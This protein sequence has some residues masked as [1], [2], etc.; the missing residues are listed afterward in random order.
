MNINVPS[1]INF[2]KNIERNN[3]RFEKLSNAKKRIAIAKDAMAQILTGSY[4][5]AP[6]YYV[7]STV[8][9]CDLTGGFVPQCRVCGIGAVMVSSFRLGENKLQLG[10]DFG[11]YDGDYFAQDDFRSVFSNKMLRKME[12]AFERYHLSSKGERFR[13]NGESYLTH[14]DELSLI[15]DPDARLFAIYANVLENDGKY[16]QRL[17]K[18]GAP[19]KKAQER[20]AEAV[21]RF[22]KA[23]AKAAKALPN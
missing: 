13:E 4:K 5:A 20:A 6:G 9:A 2:A 8:P 18:L 12:S 21:V 17:I 7:S 14:K 22:A 23:K 16:K 19:T 10:R 15:D 1:I 11:R 3:A